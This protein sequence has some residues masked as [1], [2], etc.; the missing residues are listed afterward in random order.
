MVLC[1]RVQNIPTTR[2]YSTGM[3]SPSN[4]GESRDIQLVMSN[5]CFPF[6]TTQA[7]VKE[8]LLHRKNTSPQNVY[9]TGQLYVAGALKAACI[10]LQCIGFNSEVYKALLAHAEDCKKTGRWR[11][12]ASGLGAGPAWGAGASPTLG[13]EKIKLSDVDSPVAHHGHDDGQVMKP[14]C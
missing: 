13:F 5:S 4:T 3:A 9:E 8:T 6:Q 14:V 7:L 2:Y 10:G 11:S 1:R 12:P